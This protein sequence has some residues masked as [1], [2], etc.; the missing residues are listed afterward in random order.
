MKTT[1]SIQR[2]ELTVFHNICIFHITEEYH[3][4]GS[5][6]DLPIEII[7]DHIFMYLTRFDIYKLG[8]TGNHILRDLSAEYETKHGKFFNCN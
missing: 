4:S 1:T 2:L 3:I 5:L 7:R 8:Q 6:I